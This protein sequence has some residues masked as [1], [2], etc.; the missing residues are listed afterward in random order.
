MAKKRSQKTTG[1]QRSLNAQKR[2]AEPDNPLRG[3]LL[4]ERRELPDAPGVYLFHDRDDAVIYVGK[5]VSI[6]K[7]VSSHFSAPR[8]RAAEMIAAVERIE[9]VVTK[10]ESQA[11]VTEQ[12]FIRQYRPRFNVRLRDD[13]SYP[14]IAVSHDESFPRVYFT[15]ERHKPGRRYFGPYSDARQARRT[16]EL[17]GKIFQFRTCEGAEPGRASGNPCLD[18]FIK[19]CQAPCVGYITRDEYL[20]NVERVEQ[21]LAG[22]YGFVEGQL[23]EMMREAAVRQEYEEAALYRNRLSAVRDYKERKRVAAASIGMVDIVGLAVDGDDANVHVLQV[24]DGVLADRQSFYLSNEA[25]GDVAEVAEQFLYQ[26]YLSG[27]A[28]PPEIVVPGAVIAGSGVIETIAGTLCERRGS[29][30]EIKDARRGEKRELLELARHNAQLALQREQLR[31]QH[32]RQNRREA[33]ERLRAALGMEAAPVRI[34]C[35]DVSNLGATHTVASMVVFHDGTARKGHYRRFGVDEQDGQ[36]DY[37]AIADVLRRRL[38]AFERQQDI[39]PHEH[40]YDAAFA[41]LPGLI[42][43]DGGPGQLASGLRELQ[44]FLERGVTV[45]SLAK[46]LEEIYLPG[47]REPLLLALD[48]PALQLLQRVRDEAHRFAIEF[49]RARRDRQLTASVFDDLPGVGP[50]RKRLLVKHFGSPD[51]L[52]RASRDQLESVPGLPAKVGRDIFH[53]VN[54]SK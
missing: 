36:D 18:Y 30:V 5:S 52:L 37:A 35:Y 24:R 2:A 40:E 1:V 6:K 27:G 16:V 22:R 45:V 48:D 38:T 34:E 13:K 42:V 29:R 8:G 47:R 43:I 31:V 9:C 23:E 4:D 53:Y 41:T 50:A 39:S 44:P 46:R 17:L 25:G 20:G 51:A 49:H 3:K 11:L 26:Y 15:R 14:F 33:L 32:G 12:Q 19:R 10:D 54:R 28:I 21:F 7:R